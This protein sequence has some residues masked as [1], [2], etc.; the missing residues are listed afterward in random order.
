M[1]YLNIL[2]L[3]ILSDLVFNAQ[4]KGPFRVSLCAKEWGGFGLV[5][6]EGLRHAKKY[7]FKGGGGEGGRGGENQAKNIGCKRGH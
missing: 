4:K 2:L 7:G 6:F 5:A 3:L 1:S